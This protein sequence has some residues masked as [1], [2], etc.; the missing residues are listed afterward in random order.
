M[1]A[2]LLRKCFS[3]PSVKVHP[4]G[5][6]PEMPQKKKSP[7]ER[8]AW[9]SLQDDAP[10]VDAVRSLESKKPSLVNAKR[11]LLIVVHLINERGYN[12]ASVAYRYAQM[13]Y[14]YGTDSKTFDAAIR[15]ANVM[16]IVAME[17][18]LA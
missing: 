9:S 14:P 12:K 2:I 15:L 11:D 13:M 18:D 10:F 7:E 3:N 17:H 1:F 4:D 5:Y 16:Y 8:Y 6:A